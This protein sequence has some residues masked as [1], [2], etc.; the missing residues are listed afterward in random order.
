[1]G[2]SG[3]LCEC[4]WCVGVSGKCEGLLK[5]G[6]NTNDIVHCRGDLFY[7]IRFLMKGL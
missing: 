7:K 5:R 3:D 2:V 1:M 6:V 4:G